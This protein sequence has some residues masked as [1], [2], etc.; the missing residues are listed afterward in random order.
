MTLRG[1]LLVLHDPGCCRPLALPGLKQLFRD[2]LELLSVSGGLDGA[3]H[4]LNLEALCDREFCRSVHG[5]PDT[6]GVIPWTARRCRCEC[7][8]FLRMCVD[9]DAI[10]P[11]RIDQ[12]G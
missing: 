10:V 1:V 5:H 12:R 9:A 2:G 7:N 8:R 11:A 4:P 6:G 3:V